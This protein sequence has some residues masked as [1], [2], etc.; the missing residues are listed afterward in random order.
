MKES[1][2]MIF[3]MVR[4]NIGGMMEELMRENGNKGEWKV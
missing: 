1:L 3:F 2:K 4:G